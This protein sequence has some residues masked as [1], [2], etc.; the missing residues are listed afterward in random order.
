MTDRS[1][2]DPLTA[3]PPGGSAGRPPAVV[4][5]GGIA[6]LLAAYRLARKGFRP[7][8]LE[9]RDQLGGPVS[10]HRLAGLELDAGAES[11]A[12]A[13]PAVAEL[14]TD[15]GLAD[16]IVSPAPGRAFVHHPGGA[17]PLPE[18]ALL[19]IPADL[20][21]RDVR[22]VLGDDAAAEAAARD[23][24]PAPRSVAGLPSTLGPL[25]RLRMGEAV[26]HRL[27]RPVVA[28]VYAT[29]PEQLD[30]NTVAPGLL[31]QLAATGSLAGAV[32]R[33]RPAGAPGAAVAGLDG[34]MWTLTRRLAELVTA[35]GGDIRTGAPVTQLAKIEDGYQLTVGGSPAADSVTGAVVVLAGGH[36][37]MRP[38]L[39][40]A[41]PV[42]APAA[43][44]GAG[45]AVALVTLVLDAPA[46]DAAPRGPGLLVAADDQPASSGIG[47]NNANSANTANP[48][49]AKALT[50]ATAKWPWLAGRLPS[51]LHVLRLSYGRDADEVNTI[52]DAE[53]RAVALQEAG[54]LLGVPLTTEQLVDTDVI[55]WS[56]ALPA[57]SAGHREAV[58]Q[59]RSRL[60]A[61]APTLA[62]VGAGWAGTGLAA[63]VGDTELQIADLLRR[64][65]NRATAGTFST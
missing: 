51:G 60:A 7:L 64:R 24:E 9:A 43:D 65:D 52:T 8:L 40:A 22:A 37:A 44:R 20:S 45:S 25:V 48:V 50:H 14:L 21:A 29:D 12:T 36:A 38:L 2:A 54:A 31:E 58:R 27:V 41:A 33:L 1:A 26:L 11:F 46:L 28:G 53:L 57:P 16:R 39:H 34:G 3:A 32:G 6:G 62:L 15:I 61:A 35:A 10:S 19:G 47:A 23:A 56:G 59:F 63:V 17:W 4:V 18:R 55:R 5:G 49:R 30:V 42:V 13:R